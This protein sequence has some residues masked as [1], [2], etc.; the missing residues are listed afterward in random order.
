MSSTIPPVS[1]GQK[2]SAVACYDAETSLF[3]EVNHAVIF[4]IIG[5]AILIQACGNVSAGY[6]VGKCGV[7]PR[8]QT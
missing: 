4:K 5:G 8:R 7:W 2:L 3:Y 6:E 1:H